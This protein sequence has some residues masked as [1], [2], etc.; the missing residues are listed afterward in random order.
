MPDANIVYDIKLRRGTHTAFETANPIITQSQNILVYESKENEGSASMKV[1]TSDTSRYNDLDFVLGDMSIATFDSSINL[2]GDS[3]NEVFPNRDNH[4]LLH[5]KLVANDNYLKKLIANINK[6]K[7][8]K[9]KINLDS[10]ELLIDNDQ[11]GL[12]FKLSED[13][14]LLFRFIE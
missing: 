6:V 5:S 11:D 7:P 2:E 4:K 1:G 3:Y 14:E 10:M 9:F 12:E 13:G 8:P